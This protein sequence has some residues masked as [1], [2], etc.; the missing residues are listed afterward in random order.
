MNNSSQSDSKGIHQK[1]SHLFALLPEWGQA[2][3]Q[4][5]ESWLAH[6]VPSSP[7]SRA[8]W[9][10]WERKV[11]GKNEKKNE[12]EREKN[13]YL[14]VPEPFSLVPHLPLSKSFPTAIDFYCCSISIMAN[15]FFLIWIPCPLNS[16]NYIMY[17]SLFFTIN[18]SFF[19][20]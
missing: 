9:K 3:S 5:G 7:L 16:S 18:Y 1:V 11:L 12:R 20:F 14:S 4:T 10:A 13:C 17:F 2:V 15:C 8:L 6:R 19:F